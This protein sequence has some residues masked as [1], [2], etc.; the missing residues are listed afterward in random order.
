MVAEMEQVSQPNSN[1][2]IYRN[3]MG[4]TQDLFWQIEEISDCFG[5]PL[6]EPV[7]IWLGELWV[8]PPYVPHLFLQQPQFKILS[9]VVPL[10]T[11]ICVRSWVLIYS[12]KNLIT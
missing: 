8:W 6:L 9:H 1:K 12:F 10:R 7:S 3:N 11:L 4:E 5:F 2:D